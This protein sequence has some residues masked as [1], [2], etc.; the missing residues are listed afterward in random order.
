MIICF[1]V[2]SQKKSF[3]F[4]N[5][6]HGRMRV[7]CVAIRIYKVIRMKSKQFAPIKYTQ[8]NIYMKIIFFSNSRY[9]QRSTKEAEKKIQSHRP[10]IRMATQL[11]YIVGFFFVFLLNIL[12]ACPLYTIL[13]AI[14]C[15][16]TLF[17]CHIWGNIITIFFSE[18]FGSLKVTTKIL[19][20]VLCSLSCFVWLFVFVLHMECAR[21]ITR[22]HNFHL[23][24]HDERLS[25]QMERILCV[26]FCC[27][28]FF[29]SIS[30]LFIQRGT[31][32][33]FNHF[34]LVF[35]V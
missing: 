16:N 2:E 7:L 20:V 28:Y 34:I 29:S 22:P 31:L 14:W 11:R 17:S 4:L 35:C 13:I 23:L 6:V 32:V 19:C 18:L 30:P 1:F 27:C 33:T 26:L 9:H 24:P 10:K 15:N 25:S 5:S 8:K 3:F 12:F 21:K